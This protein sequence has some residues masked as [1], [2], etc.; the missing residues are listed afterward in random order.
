MRKNVV[1]VIEGEKIKE[2]ATSVP[3][4]AEWWICRARLVCRG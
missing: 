4:G 2:I 3:G 1:I